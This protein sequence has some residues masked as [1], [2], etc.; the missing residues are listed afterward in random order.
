MSQS[1]MVQT[2]TLVNYTSRQTVIDICRQISRTTA[3][4]AIK[5]EILSTKI[6]ATKLIDESGLQESNPKP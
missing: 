5:Y 3:T 1:F 4:Q 6:A 2:T